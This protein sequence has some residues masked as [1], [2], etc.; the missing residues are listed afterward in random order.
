[1]GA[2]YQNILYEVDAG[3][4]TLTLNRPEKLNAYTLE[5]GD[6][7]VDAFA[8]TRADDA[9]RVVAAHR[10]GARLL[11]RRRSRRAASAPGE[12]VRRRGPPAGRGGLRAHA[13][14]RAARVS[15]SP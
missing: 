11:R 14:A 9:V 2:A 12:P 6:E 8:R 13:A 10:R 15:R 7:I 1:M 3:I 5:M 4:A